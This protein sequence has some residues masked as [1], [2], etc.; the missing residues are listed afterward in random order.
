MM[1]LKLEE[2]LA[3]LRKSREQMVANVNAFNGAIQTIEELIAERDK[4][5]PVK[6]PA[7]GGGANG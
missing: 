6:E 3:G 4:P 1:D 5:E 2:R 7:K